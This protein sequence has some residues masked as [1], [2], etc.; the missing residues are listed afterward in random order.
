MWMTRPPAASM[1]AAAAITSITMNGGTSLRAEG[2]I[3]RFAASSIDST[4]RYQSLQSAPL[5]PHSA[6]SVRLAEGRIRPDCAVSTCRARRNGASSTPDA[7]GKPTCYQWQ[8]HRQRARKAQSPGT[9]VQHDLGRTNDHA[10]PPASSPRRR[11][12]PPHSR[13]RRATGS[14]ARRR[15]SRAAAADRRSSATPR[16]SSCCASTPSRS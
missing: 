8:I 14:S 6:A 12:L 10:T 16:S 3:S 1:R 7:R 9:S 5:L 4:V 13:L 2:T 15:R 11:R